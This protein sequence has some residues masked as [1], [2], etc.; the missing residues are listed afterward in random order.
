LLEKFRNRSDSIIGDNEAA[1]DTC[2]GISAGVSAGP[3][4]ILAF[5]DHDRAA[6]D[7]A[8]QD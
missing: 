4:I 8:Q 3:E 7:L 6:E 1:S 5:V 2:S